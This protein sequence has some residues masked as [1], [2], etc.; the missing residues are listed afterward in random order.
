MIPGGIPIS[1]HRIFLERVSRKGMAPQG[2]SW[3]SPGK[4]RRGSL[5]WDPECILLLW[6]RLPAPVESVTKSFLCT[7]S[8]RLSVVLERLCG[9][10]MKRNKHIK[11]LFYLKRKV[12]LTI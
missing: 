11:R 3:G 12:T 4:A 8:E 9:F 5:A 6:H 2:G 1:R 7:T 10:P